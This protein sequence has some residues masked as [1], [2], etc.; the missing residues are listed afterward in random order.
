MSQP[1]LIIDN[2]KACWASSKELYGSLAGDQWDVQSHCP[3]WTVK[4]VLAHQVSVEQGLSG[5]LPESV[6]TPPPVRRDSPASS[7]R[8]W[9]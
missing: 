2:L 9:R 6:E 7:R 3:D 4:G 5:W 8:P 1:Q